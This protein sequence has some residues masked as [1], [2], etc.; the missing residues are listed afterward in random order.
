MKKRVR[1]FVEK[2]ED[3]LAVLGCAIASITCGVCIGYLIDHRYHIGGRVF[4]TDGTVVK[5]VLVDAQ[6]RYSNGMDAYGLAS[7]IRVD[8]LGELGARMMKV[9]CAADKTFTNF[10]AIGPSKK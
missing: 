6:T 7:P 2:H 4:L 5:Q 9:G 1:K 10:I 8:E 3:A